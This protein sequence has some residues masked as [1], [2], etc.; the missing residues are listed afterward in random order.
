MKCTALCLVLLLVSAHRMQAQIPIYEIIKAAVV[1]AIKAA[2]LYIQRIQNETVWLQN[3]QQKLENTLAKLKLEEISDWMEKQRELYSNYYDELQQV[4]SVIAYYHRIRDITELQAKLVAEYKR[5]Y[6]LFRNDDQFTADE[7]AFMGQVY[8]GILEKSVDNMEQI[9]LVVNAF[10][11]SMTDAERMAVI[12]RAADAVEKNYQD[13]TTF[14][15]ENQLL[16]L[17]RV[18]DAQEIQ[19]VKAMYGL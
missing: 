9:Q 12:N 14:N 7:I 11:V 4:K 3:A 17:Q 15:K 13:L 10:T 2:D 16:S 18:K 5:A 19:M 6:G 1:K 8:A